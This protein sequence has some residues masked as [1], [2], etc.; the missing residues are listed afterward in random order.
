MELSAKAK[1]VF[2]ESLRQY[3]GGG[4]VET[5]PPLPPK[6]ER[7]PLPPK[8]R[9]RRSGD[10]GEASS[11]DQ[12]YVN[13]S[14]LRHASE[15][16][17]RSRTKLSLGSSPH[18]RHNSDSGRKSSSEEKESSEFVYG[19]YFSG[20]GSTKVPVGG[21]ETETKEVIVK[22]APSLP[23]K[24]TR[25]AEV[26]SV[27]TSRPIKKKAGVTSTRI[28]GTNVKP[29]KSVETQTDESDFYLLYP[30]GV[31]DEESLNNTDSEYSPESNRSISPD[32]AGASQY[33]RSP[34]EKDQ[35]FLG[36]GTTLFERPVSAQSSS[37]RQV[38][39]A[40]PLHHRQPRRKLESVSSVPGSAG[41][42]VHRNHNDPVIAGEINW[43]VS[44]LRT[45]F[46]QVTSASDWFWFTHSFT[47]LCSLFL[48]LL[49]M[50]FRII[51]HIVFHKAYLHTFRACKREG[52]VGTTKF[53]KIF[54]DLEV[55]AG[56]RYIQITHGDA[57][58][59]EK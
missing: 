56:N 39:Q 40:S 1:A 36:T 35:F 23:P 58:D 57:I 34:A 55:Q 46:N 37:L 11:D 19:S 33:F 27:E 44:Q 28:V 2:E 51:C 16:S 7:P 54:Q 52:Q 38:Q 20:G 59:P 4:T 43:S 15:R 53:R 49:D 31:P 45:L 32:Y 13:S 14:E 24:E 9:G 26:T 22:Q 6:T 17:T 41:G 29:M 42:G 3:E 18:H 12:T 48:I 47:F 8:Q 50:Y 5:P 10:Q 30:E 21:R 25:I